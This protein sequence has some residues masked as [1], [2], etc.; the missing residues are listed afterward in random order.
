MI[1]LNSQERQAHL[2]S[3]YNG[4]DGLHEYANK[5]N[6][7]FDIRLSA[8]QSLSHLMLNNIVEAKNTQTRWDTI[9]MTAAKLNQANTEFTTEI[10]RASSRTILEPAFDDF[11]Y[12]NDMASLK[13]YGPGYRFP[14]GQ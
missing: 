10:E 1:R 14:P 8:A 6:D 4:T 9:S 2:Y 12:S 13:N 7:A 11:D 5:A 3:I